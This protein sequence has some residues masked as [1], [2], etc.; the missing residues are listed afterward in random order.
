M[1]DQHR[2]IIRAW[3]RIEQH[4]AEVSWTHKS[5]VV[6]TGGIPELVNHPAEPD[7]KPMPTFRTA[8]EAAE[9]WAKMNP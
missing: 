3:K 4:Y 6:R 1:N 9:H 8:L 7:G 2:R 5:W